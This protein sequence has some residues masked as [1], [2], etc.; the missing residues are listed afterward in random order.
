MSKMM[1]GLCA[2]MAF[3]LSGTLTVL[4]QSGPVVSN[5]TANQQAGN[6]RRVDIH[7]NLT[8]ANPCTVWV[9]VSDNGGAT[10]GVPAMTVTGHVGPNVSPGNNKL[11]VW[12]AGA[13]IPGRVGS[14]RVRVYADDGTGTGNMVLVPSGDFPYQGSTPIYIAAFLL[15][16]YEVTNLR[17]CEFLNAADPNGTYWTSGQ[18]ITRSGT[19]PYTYAVNSGRQNYP[20]RYVSHDDAVAMANW[21]SQRDNRSWRLPTEQEWEKAAAWDPTISKRWTYGFQQDTI[22][23]VWCNYYSASPGYCVGNPTEV[24]HYNG[25]NGTNNAKSFFGCYDM[26]GNVWEWTSSCYSGSP[27]SCSRVLRGGSWY[28]NA[29]VCTTTYRSGDDAPTSRD[30]YYGFRLAL[31]LN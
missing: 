3:A 15:D 9:V 21:L 7:Y 12:D 20:V 11:A 13:D 14:F 19:P 25:T 10:W 24:G 1:R 6:S 26:S 30:D 4:A 5:V 16:K 27:P 23:C 28:Y 22:S 31:D 8:N 17:Y 2:C 18:E 29:A